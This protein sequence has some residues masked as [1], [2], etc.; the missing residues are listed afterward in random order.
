MLRGNYIYACIYIYRIGKCRK[1]HDRTGR[2]RIGQYKNDN[3]KETKLQSTLRFILAGR[4][5]HSERQQ[6]C[7]HETRQ[8]QR[9]SHP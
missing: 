5:E 3:N 4:T 7:H 1:V 9:R 2:Q 6:Y 8:R